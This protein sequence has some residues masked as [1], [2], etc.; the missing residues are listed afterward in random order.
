MKNEEN[1]FCPAI[2]NGPKNLESR[3][4]KRTDLRSGILLAVLRNQLVSL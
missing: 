2:P 4:L 1:L 3:V